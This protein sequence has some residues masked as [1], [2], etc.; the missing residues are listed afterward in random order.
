VQNGYDEVPLDRE[1]VSRI[2][3]V[4]EKI[5]V[6]NVRW[7]CDKGLLMLYAKIF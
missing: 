7:T 3:I 2:N 6:T 5:T 1:V 4:L